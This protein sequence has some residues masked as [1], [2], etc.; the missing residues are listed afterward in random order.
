MY[1]SMVYGCFKTDLIYVKLRSIF[2][3]FML[4]MKNNVSISI[5]IECR[6]IL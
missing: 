6:H 4:T 5:C 1:A 3:H 2:Q